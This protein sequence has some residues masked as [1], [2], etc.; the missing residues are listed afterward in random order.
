MAIFMVRFRMHRT[1]GTQSTGNAPRVDGIFPRAFEVAIRA[2]SHSWVFQY[3]VSV[4]GPAIC[5]RRWMLIGTSDFLLYYD[6]IRPSS[7][8][9]LNIHA[10]KIY[11]KYTGLPYLIY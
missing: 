7:L 4:E 11:F 3:P 5:P 1:T 2:G 9:F 10:M 6:G 8:L